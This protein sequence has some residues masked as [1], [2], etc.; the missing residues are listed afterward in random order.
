MVS[1]WVKKM[2]RKTKSFGNKLILNFTLIVFGGFLTVYF[3]FNMIMNNH[4]RSEAE[5]E[6]VREITTVIENDITVNTPITGFD[7]HHPFD[8]IF[9][10]PIRSNRTILNVD[11]ILLDHNG[12]LLLPTPFDLQEN[13]LSKVE[14]LATFYN[15]NGSLFED[16]DEM[17]MVTYDSHTFYMRATPHYLV[18]SGSLSFAPIPVSVLMYT[19]ITPAM[20]L[21]NS[22]NQILLVLLGISG[23]M[24]LG[25]SIILSSRFKKSINRLAEHAEVIGQ[26]HFNELIDSFTYAEFDNLASSM[27]NMSNML[28]SY[29][30]NQKQFFQNASHE[31]RTPLMSIQGYTEGIQ[32]GVFT[33]DIATD[34][35][36]EESKKMTELVDDILYL[37]RLNNSEES[38]LNLSS[39]DIDTLLTGCVERVRIIAEKANKQVA[40]YLTPAANISMKSD[41]KKL[42]RAIINILTNAIRY[43]A[44]VVQITAFRLDDELKI[45]ITNDGPLIDEKDLPHL[46]DRFYK[47]KGGNTGIGLAITQD[48]VTKLSGNVEA[49][50]LNEGVQFVI[51]LSL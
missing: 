37:S 41:S 16:Q 17:V 26:G 42:E 20:H 18:H 15:K 25:I 1:R 46:F 23:A 44:C 51:T 39:V 45:I 3:L 31:L 33:A 49:K 24:S 38:Q 9:S 11:T 4:I 6:L 10:M 32:L 48:I 28:G 14:A 50:N 19:N 35:I 8:I 30:E 7:G 12:M 43:A 47:G 40:G 36:L 13:D 27:N 34:V 22:M 21:K 29:E 5:A 2:D